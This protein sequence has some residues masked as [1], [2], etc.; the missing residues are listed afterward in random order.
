M[1]CK[2]PPDENDENKDYGGQR[3]ILPQHGIEIDVTRC[4]AVFF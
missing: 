4:L 3:S 2:P 1:S